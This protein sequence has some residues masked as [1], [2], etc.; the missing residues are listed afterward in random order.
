M[1]LKTLE[2][3][4]R[5]ALSA[6]SACA[7]YDLNPRTMANL[8]SLKQGPQFFKVNRKIFY[9]PEHIE[10]WL[11]ENPVLTVNSLPEGR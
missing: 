2:L 3:P 5:K 6:A 10:S 9:R 7:S 4:T 11:F 1:S 8:R